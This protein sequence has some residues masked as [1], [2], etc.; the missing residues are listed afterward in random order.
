MLAL[1]D[2]MDL[3]HPEVEKEL[4][5]LRKAE[6]IELQNGVAR[7]NSRGILMYDSVAESIIL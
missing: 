3:I 2:G 6:L 5:E 1:H 7:L 4:A